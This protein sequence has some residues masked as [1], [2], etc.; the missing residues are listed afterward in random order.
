MSDIGDGMSRNTQGNSA[1]EAIEHA[2]LH[3]SQRHEMATSLLDLAGT[4][5]PD[6]ARSAMDN[7]HPDSLDDLPQWCL[8]DDAT[9]QQ[10]GRLLGA[11]FLAPALKKCIDG[12]RLAQWQSV[13]GPALFERVMAARFSTQLNAVAELPDILTEADEA[14]L[15]AN[16]ASL[17]LSTLSDEAVRS[18][19]M[20]RFNAHHGLVSLK[21]A[22]EIH[23]VALMI[24]QQITDAADAELVQGADSLLTKRAMS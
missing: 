11:L 4:L 2:R 14:L 1:A 12:S 20:Q 16:G 3:R 10:F 23:N 8:M 5:E 17:L 24:I 18:L 22:Q 9:L 21:L 7:L 13:M 6:L 19:M 15:F